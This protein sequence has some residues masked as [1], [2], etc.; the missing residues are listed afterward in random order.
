MQPAT[1]S[2]VVAFRSQRF[3]DVN[4]EI[5]HSKSTRSRPTTTTETTTARSWAPPTPSG[6][7]W[8]VG[9]GVGLL[10]SRRL[11]KLRCLRDARLEQ[12]SPRDRLRR[13]PCSD[14]SRR[15]RLRPPSSSRRVWLRTSL[16]LVLDLPGLGLGEGSFLT[17]SVNLKSVLSSFH[18]RQSSGTSS[19]S[20]LSGCML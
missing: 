14:S 15:D 8:W 5:G 18:Y 11:F 6:W 16:G 20:R 10:E 4:Q 17:A 1:H 7:W 3:S 13:R 2:L 9:V 12:C 19:S